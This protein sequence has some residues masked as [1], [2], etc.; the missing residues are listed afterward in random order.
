VAE[1][2]AA[3]AL[4]TGTPSRGTKAPVDRAAVTT[5]R[6]LSPCLARA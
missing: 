5:Q 2:A 4:I 1:A 3:G 6:P